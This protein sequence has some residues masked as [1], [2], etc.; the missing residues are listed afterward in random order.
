[1]KATARFAWLVLT[2]P[3]RSVFLDVV[4]PGVSPEH[5]ERIRAMTEGFAELLALFEEQG[6]SL[7]R[8][9]KI[10]FGAPTEKTAH[11][12]AP[13][14]LA[15]RPSDTPKR[16]RKGHGRRGAAAYTG[17]RRVRVSHPTFT[18][19]QVCPECQKGKLRLQPKVATAIHLQAQPPISASVYE[20][21]VLRCSLCGKTLTAPLPA[22][23]GQEKFD[24]SVGVMTGLLRYGAGMPFYRLEQWQQN[25]GVPLPASTQWELVDEVARQI[26]PVAEQLAVVAAQA[27]TVFNDD[28][29]MRVGQLRQEIQREEKPKRTG[30]FTTG[31]VAQAPDHPIAL[32]FTGRRHAGENL[33]QV[34]QHRAKELPPPLQMCDGLSRNEPKESETILACC[35]A[36]GRR[37][38]VEVAP[39]FPKECRY[40]LEALQTVYQ[41]DA[42]AKEKGLSAQERLRLHQA[43][44]QPVMDELKTWLGQQIEQ[45]Q[46]E[47]NS[48]L[49]EAIEY[50]LG[51]WVELTRFLHVP[52]APLDNNVCERLLKTAILHRKNSLSYK[53]QRGAR[54]G[55]IFMTVIQTSRL[56]LTNPFDYLMALVRHSAEVKAN[57]T[58]WLPWNFRDAL[59]QINLS[60][61]KTANTT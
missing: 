2:E 1:M 45:K 29:T 41:C 6:T 20:L 48:G 12:C 33:N 47:P 32:F 42:Q 59:S 46:V 58:R 8:V 13:E 34:L 18:T 54:V 50:M 10:A 19:D 31:V 4:R 36:H 7:E 44:S 40:V 30:I 17:A 57:V 5:F 26:E 27:P 11:I 23:A 37:G 3:E 16:R 52:G 21:E 25:L 14:K 60:P 53:T 39:R 28:T 35:L 55:D 15:D 56:N 22:E 61:P 24:P 9:R 38:F 49:G 51:H 43:Q